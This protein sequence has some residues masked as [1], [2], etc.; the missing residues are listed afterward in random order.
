VVVDAVGGA[1]GGVAADGR[2]RMM[3]MGSTTDR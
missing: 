1:R 2:G 3:G